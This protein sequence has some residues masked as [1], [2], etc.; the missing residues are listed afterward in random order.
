MRDRGPHALYDDRASSTATSTSLE[1]LSPE[2]AEAVHNR[3][4][5]NDLSHRWVLEPERVAVAVHLLL[6]S[7]RPE[8]RAQS[9]TIPRSYRIAPSERVT[10]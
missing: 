1:F 5:D 3:C 6:S 8:R 7:A 9:T 4:P 10:R 2:T